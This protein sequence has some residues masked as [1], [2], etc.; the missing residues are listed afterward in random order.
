MPVLVIDNYDS[1][2]YNLYQMIQALTEESVEVYR[3]DAIDLQGVLDRKP[4]RV[5]L[6]PG[7]GHPGVP[8]DFGVCR[9]IIL[10]QEVLEAPVLGVCL[11]HQGIVHHL[12]GEVIQAPVICHGKTSSI[13]FRPSKEAQ[14]PLFDS[15][16]NPFQAMRYHS[17]VANEEGFPPELEVTAREMVHGLIMGL[18]HRTRPLY[19][20]QFHPESIGTPEG[21]K[22]LRNFL[23]KC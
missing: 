13:G 9:D 11:G 6:S 8:T 15:L 17:L 21:S 7:P 10:Q 19:G 4:S 3:N 2:T 14:S 16:P 22:L 12:G 23:E 1:F 20:V 5:I 18:Q